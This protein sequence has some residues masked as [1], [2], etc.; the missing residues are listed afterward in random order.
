MR[1]EEVGAPR[2]TVMVLGMTTA[3]RTRGAAAGPA[4]AGEGPL[5]PSP[6]KRGWGGMT[7]GSAGSAMRA[8]AGTISMGARVVWPEKIWMPSMRTVW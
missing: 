7:T 6:A 3:V 4:R 2:W 1:A 5:P 8:L